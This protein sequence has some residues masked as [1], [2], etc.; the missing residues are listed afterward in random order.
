MWINELFINKDYIIIKLILF[1][2]GTMS[3][4]APK[5]T[6][7]LFGTAVELVFRKISI[8]FLLKLSVVCT[9][10]IVLMC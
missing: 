9:F 10:W 8:F 5:M 2:F 7:Y 3:I 4:V 6:S 1:I